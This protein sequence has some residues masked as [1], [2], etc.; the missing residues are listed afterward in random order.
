MNALGRTGRAPSDVAKAVDVETDIAHSLVVNILG[1]FEDVS[2]NVFASFDSLG[3][4]IQVR[5]VFTGRCQY[6]QEHRSHH[7][8]KFTE[9]LQLALQCFEW[10]ELF[11]IGTQPESKKA[12]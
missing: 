2:G 5:T 10:E 3:Q 6:W 12:I 1:H 7:Q 11:R 4:I 9:F 8:A